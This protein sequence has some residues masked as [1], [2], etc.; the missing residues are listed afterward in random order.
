MAKRQYQTKADSALADKLRRA[1]GPLVARTTVYKITLD[2]LAVYKSPSV[3]ARH[4]HERISADPELSLALCEL[5][6][7]RMQ[8]DKNMP[9]AGQ[10]DPEAQSTSAQPRHP[11]EGEA[12]HGPGANHS[13][14]APS[15]SSHHDRAG[16][17]IIEAQATDARPVVT[18][19][20]RGLADI[21]AIQ[22]VLARSMFRLP[23]GRDVRDIQWHELIKLARKYELAA[24]VLRS[25]ESHAQNVD[26]FAY[27]RD[28]VKDSVLERDIKHAKSAENADA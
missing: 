8:R 4:L 27:V 14:S 19:A 9:G 5:F 12:G 1:N 13:M 2:F 6:T 18:H 17:R 16:Q 15:P 11:V 23:D 26:P 24:R 3:A 22:P 28:V 20:R 21:A 25:I 7:D 10:R